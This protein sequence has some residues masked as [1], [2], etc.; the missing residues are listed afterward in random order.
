[1][2][3]NSIRLYRAIAV[4]FA[5]VLWQI[6]AVKVGK[7]MLLASPVSVLFRFGTVFAEPGFIS[8][9]LFSY[10]RIMAGFFAAFFFGTVLGALAGR[11]PLIEHFLFPYVITVKTVPVASFIILSLIWLNYNTLTVLISFLIVFP[12]FYTNVLTGTRSTPQKMKELAQL[13]N[14]PWHRQ[15]L[16]IYIPSVKPYLLSACAAGVG[17]AWKAGAAAEVIGIIDGSI[18]EKLYYAKVYFQNADLLCW[19][20]IIILLSVLSEKLFVLLMKALFRG[21][22]KL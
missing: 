19:T 1:M 10:L 3:K 2:K 20:L 21:V 15:L 11:I 12:V 16:Y 14:V 6:A 9:V 4:L 7:E 13:Y 17:M 22:E 8:T 5:L 18:G